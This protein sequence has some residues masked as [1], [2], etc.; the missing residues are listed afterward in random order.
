LANDLSAVLAEII[1]AAPSLHRAGT[2][3]SRVLEAIAR[4]AASQRTISCSAETGSGASTLLFSQLSEHH[5]VFAVDDG[6]ESISAVKASSL[7]R[8]G[9][10]T[11]IEGPTQLTLPAHRFE[12]KLQLALI[13]GPHAYPFPDLEYY[14][15]YEHLDQEALLIVDDIHIRS[16]S[17]LFEFLRA[18][19]MFELMEVVETTAF[20]RRTHAPA[21]P[22]LGDGWWMQGYNRRDFE[23]TLVATGTSDGLKRVRTATPFYIDELGSIKNPTRQPSLTVPAAEPLVVAGWAIDLAGQH[24][25]A[26]FEIVLDRTPY[27]TEVRIPR[28]DVATAHGDIRYFRCGFRAVLPADRLAPGRHTLAFRIVLQGSRTYYESSEIVFTAQ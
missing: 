16:I 11:F 2:F 27:R 15:L 22:R 19:D 26:W 8:P 14:Y 23:A 12:R 21:F 17:N 5:S 4:H 1:Q 7:L 24:P 18:D 13:D 20:F 3:S 10:V 28:G 25:A 9:I 6:T